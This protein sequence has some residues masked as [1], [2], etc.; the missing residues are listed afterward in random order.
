[1][2]LM[3]RGIKITTI[4]VQGLSGSESRTLLFQWLSCFDL[5]ILCVQ[6]TH[7]TSIQEFSSWVEEI[8]MLG[9]RHTR[10]CAAKA[11]WVVRSCG[12]AILY[13]PRFPG[14]KCKEG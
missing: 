3:T 4:N 14:F 5:D 9:P 11:Y 10:N 8:I 7:A 6:E 2:I 13:R 1:M 12:I